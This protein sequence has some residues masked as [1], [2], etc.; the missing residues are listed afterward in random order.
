MLSFQDT[1]IIILTVCFASFF[2]SF[3]GYSYIIQ[4]APEKWKK[5][6]AKKMEIVELIAEI[7]GRICRGS[8]ILFIISC[9]VGSILKFL[10]YL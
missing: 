2:L 9:C 3:L 7:F 4:N 8:C 5:K 1:L 10:K 6:E